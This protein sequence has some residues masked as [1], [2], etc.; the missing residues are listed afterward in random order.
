MD[1]EHWIIINCSK[2]YT[3]MLDPN[4]P[5]FVQVKLSVLRTKEKNEWLTQNAWFGTD[6]S[7]VPAGMLD[8]NDP[9]LSCL[10]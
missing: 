1:N 6:H 8:S 4:D 10:F 9:L 2:S 3:R 7:R 5:Y